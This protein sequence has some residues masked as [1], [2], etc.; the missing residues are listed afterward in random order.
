MKYKIITKV[1]SLSK[2]IK[3]K[4]GLSGKTS[5]MGFKSREEA[6]K[7]LSKLGG[8]RNDKKTKETKKKSKK[9]TNKSK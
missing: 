6:L 2:R 5:I 4:Y 3:F 7:F 9:S 1:I 8:K